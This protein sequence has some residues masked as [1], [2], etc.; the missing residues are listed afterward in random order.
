MDHGCGAKWLFHLGFRHMQQSLGYIY[1]QATAPKDSQVVHQQ[2]FW[3]GA[4]CTACAWNMV[5]IPDVG[6]QG[7]S[8]GERVFLRTLRASAHFSMVNMIFLFFRNSVHWQQ[9]FSK[10]L[11][12]P[13][14]KH[15]WDGN[16]GFNHGSLHSMLLGFYTWHHQIPD[17]EQDG[18]MVRLKRLKFF[19]SVDGIDWKHITKRLLWWKS[20]QGKKWICCRKLRYSAAICDRLHQAWCRERW[21]L[22]QVANNCKNM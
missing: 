9:F 5:V 13:L 21:R 2:E 12:F 4:P 16:Y 14:S 11:L 10:V 7:H 3:S 8:F 20:H 15:R 6:R 19:Q 1:I 22:R 17:N 18:R